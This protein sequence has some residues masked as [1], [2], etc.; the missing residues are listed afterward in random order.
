[1]G[2]LITYIV[3][4][5]FIS[6]LCSILEAVLLSVT[7]TFIKV[8]EQEGRSYI[9]SLKSLKKDVDKP[10]IAILTLNTL[11]HTVGAI[12]VG[13]QAENMVSESGYNSSYLGIPFVGIVSGIMTVLILVVS[14]IIPKTIGATYWKNL[15]GFTTGALNLMIFPL[16][17][18]GVLWILQLTTKAIGKSAHMNTMTREDFVAITETA[19]QEGVFAPSEGQYIKSLMNFNKIE[20][21]DIMTPRSVMF[22]APQSMKIKDFFEQNQDLRFSRIPVFGENRDDI[23]G[24]VLKDHILADI[25]YDKPA[26][27][28]EDLRREIAMV[29]AN[30]P[31]PKLFETMIASKEHMALVVDDYGSVQGV[32]TM[33]D[34]IETMLGLEIMDESDNVEDM[35]LLARKN[36]EKRSRSF[37]K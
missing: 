36:W 30:L 35:Q 3:I 9:G 13:V 21:K 12:L 11:A 5:I 24:Y 15:A 14:E 27:T 10:L 19:E 29:P 2:L 6:F 7:S 23:K 17:W 32:A 8:N 4:S 22:M 25:I 34:V 26:D 33:E 20:V 1:M 28:L 37:I 16:K 31:I 18:L